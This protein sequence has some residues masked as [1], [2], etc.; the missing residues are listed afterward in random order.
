M[1]DSI[2]AGIVYHLSRNDLSASEEV[3]DKEREI[4]NESTKNG[5]HINIALEETSEK[6]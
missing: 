5:G 3:T 4:I 2:G 1:G 6:L